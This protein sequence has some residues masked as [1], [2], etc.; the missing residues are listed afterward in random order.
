MKRS[1]SKSGRACD[2]CNR[3][4]VAN[5]QIHTGPD[6]EANWLCEMCGFQIYARKLQMGGRFAWGYY[7]EH[8]T[9]TSYE[10]LAL[11]NEPLPK[12]ED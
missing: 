8:A 7:I 12:E 1:P 3:G 9:P 10:E 6:R 4:K 2:C 11:I 5:V